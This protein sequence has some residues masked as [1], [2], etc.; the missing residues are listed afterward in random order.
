MRGVCKKCGCTE[1]DPCF[2]PDYG[3][4]WWV[5]DSHELCSHCADEEIANDPRTKHCIGSHERD[6][7]E[8]DEFVAVTAVGPHPDDASPCDICERERCI[9]VE[10]CLVNYGENVYFIRRQEYES[11]D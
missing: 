10:A 9:G 2:H 6:E 11:D 1:N 5:D 4:C 7:H 8:D 3:C